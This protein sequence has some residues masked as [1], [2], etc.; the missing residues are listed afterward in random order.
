MTLS[1]ESRASVGSPL[2]RN[3]E[4]GV[5]SLTR[6]AFAVAVA[7]A[8]FEAVCESFEELDP[9]RLTAEFVGGRSDEDRGSV[10]VRMLAERKGD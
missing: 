9:A 4:R 6:L 7:V 1:I 5:L 2:P 10:C 3:C 8:L